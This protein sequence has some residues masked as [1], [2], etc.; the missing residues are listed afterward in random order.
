MTLLR[1][2]S[3]GGPGSKALS[4][5]LRA[6]GVRALPYLLEYPVWSSVQ[7]HEVV[8]PLLLEHAGETEKA[9]LFSR[10]PT[11]LRLFEV[12]V[13]KG[14][15]ADA[16][17]PMRERVTR[18]QA[19]PVAAIRRLAEDPELATSDLAACALL[20]GKDAGVAVESLVRRADFDRK[21][22][23]TEGWR[24]RKYG[25]YGS[26]G[27]IYAAWAAEIGDRS[28]LRRFAEEAARGKVRERDRLKSLVP[29]APDHLI[30]FLRQH[31]DALKFD[32]ASGTW[33]L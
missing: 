2:G 32:P 17:P 8:R 18:R 15:T 12:F 19:V 4:E 33:G 27:W 6:K 21:S 31:L 30:D 13:E 14:W 9:R 25:N 16:L 20:L 10:L 23:V 1:E 24:R 22:F 11:D 28:A 7:W 29:G 26:E 3:V 5:R